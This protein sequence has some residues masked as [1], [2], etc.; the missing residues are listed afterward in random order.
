M[1]IGK[2]FLEGRFSIS[3]IFTPHDLETIHEG[4]C[5]REIIRNVYKDCG[6][7]ML[8]TILLLGNEKDLNA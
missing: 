3:G 8:I 1:K 7:R 6:I 4:I 5:A 2:T